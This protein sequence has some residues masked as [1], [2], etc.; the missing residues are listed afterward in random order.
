M[1]S[2]QIANVTSN[3]CQKPIDQHG[4]QT[5]QRRYIEKQG[6]LYSV[7]TRIYYYCIPH[8]QKEIKISENLITG[9][10]KYIQLNENE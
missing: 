7:I 8:L 6:H 3:D 9:F 5:L 1:T 10:Y 4:I 2:N